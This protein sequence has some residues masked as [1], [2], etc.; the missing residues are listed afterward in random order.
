MTPT[1][2]GV[3]LAGG[4]SSRM[5]SAKADLD[6]HGTPLVGHVASTLQ[7]ALGGGPVVV[8]GAPGQVL[9]PLPSSVRLAADDAAGRG[10]LQGLATG[11][12]ALERQGIGRA[13]VLATDQPFAAAL[14]A[15]L[16]SVVRPDDDAVAITLEGRLQPLGALYATRLA[17]TARERLEAGADASLRG[18]LAAVRTR[19][20]SGTPDDARAL[21]SLD[22][23]QAYAAALREAD[24]RS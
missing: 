18:L 5:G 10:P 12:A 23:P 3:V 24:V 22:T 19:T 21:R 9:P 2:G 13:V 16:L 11:L 4:R 20:L 15:R 14:A 7:D 1:A 6:W 8:V 17:R